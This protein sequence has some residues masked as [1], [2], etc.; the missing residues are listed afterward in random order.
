MHQPF[1]GFLGLRLLSTYSFWHTDKTTPGKQKLKEEKNLSAFICLWGSCSRV[2]VL[3]FKPLVTACQYWGSSQW[4]ERTRGFYTGLL[5]WES[6]EN[7]ICFC[8]VCFFFSRNPVNGQKTFVIHIILFLWKI[9]VEGKLR[10]TLLYTE[11]NASFLLSF[12]VMNSKQQITQ[13]QCV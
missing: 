10:M 4:W 7:M 6:K 13:L 1:C 9:K 12:F 5:R 8:F 2:S 11:L 3:Q